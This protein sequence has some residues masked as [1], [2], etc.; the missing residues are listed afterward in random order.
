MSV[1]K[2]KSTEYN[3]KALN[4]VERHLSQQIASEFIE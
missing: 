3:S 1:A 2:K 4:A